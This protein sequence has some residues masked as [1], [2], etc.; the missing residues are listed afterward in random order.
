M[1][2]SPKISLNNKLKVFCLYKI[3]LHEKFLIL[4]MKI[5]GTEKS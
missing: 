4:L 5:E 3:H 2:N 1:S